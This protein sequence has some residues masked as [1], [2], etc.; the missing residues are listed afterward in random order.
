MTVA[1]V[2][3]PILPVRP[4][5]DAGRLQGTPARS[6]SR[7]PRPVSPMPR[8]MKRASSAITSSGCRGRGRPAGRSAGRT[9]S[10]P[11]TWWA[12]QKALA[13]SPASARRSPAPARRLEAGGEGGQDPLDHPVR[14]QPDILAVLEQAVQRQPVV[15]VLLAGVAQLRPARRAGSSG[16][17][18]RTSDGGGGLAARPAA[19]AP[20]RPRSPGAGS[21]DRAPP[22][23][24]SAGTPAPRTRRPS[25]RSAWSWSRRSHAA[26][27]AAWPPRR[28][29]RGAPRHGGVAWSWKVSKCLLYECQLPAFMVGRSAPAPD[30]SLCRAFWG[31]ARWPSE[32]SLAALRR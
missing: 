31:G 20:D 22:C 3:S 15:D 14:D 7:S 4:R 9:R 10:W 28:W 19:R 2:S 12:N 25:A 1:I 26:R 11:P 6:G 8:R 21:R 30:R 23:S 29:R 18:S 32:W 13:A 5:L 17:P 27:T 24:G 16:R